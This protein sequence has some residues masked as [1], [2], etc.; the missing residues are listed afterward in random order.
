MEESLKSRRIY[1]H[2]KV[3]F[4]RSS[5]ECQ[6]EYF[7]KGKEWLLKIIIVGRLWNIHSKSNI[8]V[9]TSVYYGIV[10]CIHGLVSGR[11]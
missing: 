1:Y 2:K 7:Q 9:I 10:I 8:F 3:I 4:R 6:E 11:Q 5:G